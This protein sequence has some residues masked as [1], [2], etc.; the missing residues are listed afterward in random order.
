MIFE[1]G[2]AP[3]HYVNGVPAYKHGEWPGKT[4]CKFN[5]TRRVIRTLTDGIIFNGKI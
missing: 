4:S 1:Y 5:P 2:K 3:M